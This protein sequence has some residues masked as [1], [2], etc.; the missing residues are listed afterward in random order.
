MRIYKRCAATASMGLALALGTAAGAAG[1]GN[2]DVPLAEYRA[3]RYVSAGGSDRGG[4]GSKSK[5]WQTISHALAQVGS[6]AATARVAVLVAAGTYHEPTIELKANV[7]LFGGHEAATWTR[8]ISR[9]RSVLDGEERHRLAIGADHARLDGFVLKRGRVRG[10]GGALLCDGA[11]PTISNNIFLENSTEA[12]DPWKPAVM[13]ETANDGGAIAAINGAAPAI[14]HN[15]F[16]RNHTENGRGGAIA[17][18]HEASPRIAGNVMVQN[19]TGLNDPMRSSDG[20]ALSIYDRSNPLVADNIIAANRTLNNNDAGGI[21]VALWSQPRI[22]HN[23]IVGNMSSDD[24][25]GIFLGGQKHHYG[26]PLDPIPPAGSFLVRLIGNTIIANQNPSHN[27]GAARITMQARAELRDN[28]IARNEAGLYL[29]TSGVDARN[30]TVADDLLLVNDSKA[31][32]ELPGPTYLV[33]NIFW[34]RADLRMDATIAYNDFRF[35]HPGNANL[36]KDPLFADDGWSGAATRLVRDA[37]GCSTSCRLAGLSAD[38]RLAGRAIRFGDFWTVVKDA[39]SGGVTVW[40]VV[41][42][43]LGDGPVRVEIVPSYRLR[44]G[45][46][47]LGAGENG[48]NIGAQK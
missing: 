39:G 33:N 36:D 20:G 43:E 48:G 19:I 15:L 32:R 16:A 30:N 1:P 9:F 7:D 6:P 42:P 34:G 18:D 31:S 28:I 24:A 45:S 44:S 47:C 12:P 2:Q 13:H 25:G 38:E 14:E 26:T 27:S 8:D 46:P 5:P 29:Q 11:S 10:K 4:D 40:G 41:P 21:F 17:C 23:L 3:I 35:G 22:E 37:A